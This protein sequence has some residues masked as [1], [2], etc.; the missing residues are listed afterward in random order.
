MNDYIT[1][2]AELHS[3]TEQTLQRAQEHYEPRARASS[4]TVAFSRLKDRLEDIPETSQ[5]VP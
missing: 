2:K 4:A 3:R 5:R 1:R